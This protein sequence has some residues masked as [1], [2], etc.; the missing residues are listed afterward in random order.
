MDFNRGRTGTEF[1]CTWDFGENFKQEISKIRL[2]YRPTVGSRLVGSVIAFSDDGITWE[3]NL[4]FTSSMLR[5]DQGVDNN[6]CLTYLAPRRTSFRYVR[7]DG[8][9]A[10]S[11]N[12]YELNE[13][14]CLTVNPG[15]LSTTIIV[16]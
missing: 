11:H 4:V 10:V 3:T 6:A 15:P 8:T 16:R 9:G 1:F 7:L 2:W 5:T 12:Y 13:F 14:E